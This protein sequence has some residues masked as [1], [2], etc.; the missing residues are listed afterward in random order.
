MSDE[1]LFWS[2]SFYLLF[3]LAVFFSCTKGKIKETSQEQSLWRVLRF[4]TYLF[5]LYFPALSY[6]PCLF[7]G[8]NGSIIR[9]VCLSLDFVFDVN[10][11]KLILIISFHS[12][13][14]CSTD[15]LGTDS[16]DCLTKMHPFCDPWSRIP[17][18]IHV[19]CNLLPKWKC[20]YFLQLTLW[21]K[22]L[23]PLSFW[24]S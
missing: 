13:S 23:C 10:S 3:T 21:S 7:C 16:S 15:I 20:F 1:L 14:W 18:L 5:A 6:S 4:G 19:P 2:L 22:P 24:Y 17:F 12:Q 9:L 11:E 8:Y